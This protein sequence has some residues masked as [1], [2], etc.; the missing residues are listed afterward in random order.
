MKNDLS[1]AV[2]IKQLKMLITC[3]VVDSILFVPFATYLFLTLLLT[4]KY[5]SRKHVSR[6]TFVRSVIDYEGNYKKA[7]YD[8]GLVGCEKIEEILLRIRTSSLT[9]I[10]AID[11]NRA[12]TKTLIIL[13]RT[14][15]FTILNLILRR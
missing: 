13:W 9:A 8:S 2:Y 5:V 12:F 11:P 3:Y 10:M 14:W 1:I 6:S 15:K 4:G 7:R